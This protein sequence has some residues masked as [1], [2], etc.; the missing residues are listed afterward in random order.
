MRQVMELRLSSHLIPPSLDVIAAAFSSR[1]DLVV[2][3]ATNKIMMVHQT[4]NTVPS[5]H[6]RPNDLAALSRYALLSKDALGPNTGTLRNSSLNT[7]SYE[8]E[9]KQ[10][11]KRFLQTLQQHHELDILVHLLPDPTN[12][13]KFTLRFFLLLRGTKI[14]EKE[15]TLNLAMSLFVSTLKTK[16]G[17]VYQPAVIK[18][19]VDQCF[20]VFRSNGI[21]YSVPDLRSTKGSFLAQ[22]ADIF[23]V[24]AEKDPDYGRRPNKAMVCMND[25]ELFRTQAD[26]PIDWINIP[27]DCLRCVVYKVSRLTGTRGGEVS[28]YLLSLIVIETSLTHSCFICRPTY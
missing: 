22:C 17:K 12:P 15:N 11:F 18:K 10:N 2:D 16:K 27:E 14:P 21:E 4:S 28:R 6:D 3:E 25:E 13:K 24:E 1:T 8:R 20:A 26:P 5:L 23:R 7:K 19:F 9:K